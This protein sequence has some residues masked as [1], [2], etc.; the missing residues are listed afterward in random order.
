[1]GVAGNDDLNTALTG[2]CFIAF[3]PSND[4][5]CKRLRCL[6]LYVMEN[7]VLKKI[8]EDD[9][10]AW[11]RN[12]VFIVEKEVVVEPVLV[13]VAVVDI[14]GLIKLWKFSAGVAG[15]L[16]TFE[17]LSTSSMSISVHQKCKWI[18]EK[19]KDEKFFNLQ[20]LLFDNDKKKNGYSVKFVNKMTILFSTATTITAAKKGD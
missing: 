16:N 9:L 2:G 8:P 7:I 19:E 10:L 12:G 14:V 4:S 13:P 15:F 6:K 5:I 18:G 17:L 1:M 3:K 20:N 11:E